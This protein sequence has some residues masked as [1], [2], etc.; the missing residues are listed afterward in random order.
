MF[1]V[2]VV[3]VNHYLSPPVVDLDVNF[4]DF[5]NTKVTQVPV[6]RIFGS[7]PAGQKTCLHV[8]GV[9]P[10]FYVPCDEAEVSLKFLQ[11]LALS[12][13]TALQVGSGNAAKYV[14]HVF[15]IIPVS[16]RQL[17][18]YRSTERQF[19]KIYFYNPLVI[20][21][22]SELLQ[23]GA[24]LNRVFQPYECHVPFN[25]QFF[26]DYN[27]Y[28]MNLVNLAAVKFR[29]SKNDDS[30][31][32]QSNFTESQLG[33]TSMFNSVSTQHW[34][35]SNIPG[36]Q[37]LP[38]DVNRQSTC[39]LE[40]DGVATD[41]LNRLDLK[42]H[43]DTN[44][45]LVAIWED[46][47]QR[48]EQLDQLSQLMPPASPERGE[49]MLQEAES[50]WLE[51]LTEVVDE[52]LKELE[53]H[54]PTSEDDASRMENKEEQTAEK[55]TDSLPTS[56]SM[57]NQ[58]VDH[59]SQDEASP[60]QEDNVEAVV[61]EELALSL[62]QVPVTGLSQ[63]ADKD[64]ANLLMELGGGDD[65]DSDSILSTQTPAASQE[66]EDGRTDDAAEE[67]EA[68]EKQESLEMSQ[69]WIGDD[70]DHD[71]EDED[72]ET[73]EDG[74]EPRE[75]Q[76]LNSSLEEYLIPDVEEMSALSQPELRSSQ[77]PQLDG[78]NDPIPEK[79]R[80]KSKLE[81]VQEMRAIRA[82]HQLTR[83]LTPI[84]PNFSPN[85][86]SVKSPSFLHSLT[87]GGTNM[88]L[89]M[90]RKNVGPQDGRPPTTYS[91]E[92]VELYSQGY[93]Q[94]MDPPSLQNRTQSFV[95]STVFAECVGSL[96]GGQKKLAPKRGRPPGAFK[97]K[98]GGF[99]TTSNQQLKHQSHSVT[100]SLPKLS[101]DE[102]HIRNGSPFSES[103][104]K[105]VEKK[106]GR[107]PLSSKQR[108]VGLLSKESKKS[109]KGRN[110][111]GSSKSKSKGSNWHTATTDEK[112]VST[113][114]ERPPS[115]SKHREDAASDKVSK[116]KDISSDGAV[117]IVHD[118]SLVGTIKHF[119]NGSSKKPVIKRGR[120][121]KKKKIQFVGTL[122]ESTT[123]SKYVN[124]SSDV[125]K[126][127][128]CNKMMDETFLAKGKTTPSTKEK[129]SSLQTNLPPSKSTS[130]NTQREQ[131]SDEKLSAG[132]ISHTESNTKAFTIKKRRGRPPLSI[133]KQR[134]GTATSPESS[135][136][137]LK[138][139][140]NEVKSLAIVKEGGVT[141]LSSS[142]VKPA[143]RRGRPPSKWK[144]KKETLQS[145][146]LPVF[147]EGGIRESCISHISDAFQKETDV[148]SNSA[149]NGTLGFKG[150]NTNKSDEVLVYNSEVKSSDNLW[151]SPASVK[152]IVGGR[153][154][155]GLAQKKPRKRGR[156]PL[157]KKKGENLHDKYLTNIPKQRKD[158]DG[159]S[160]MFLEMSGG[161][162]KDSSSHL[163]STSDAESD[164][165][166]H[167]I[168]SDGSPSLRRL[169]VKL[170]KV[171]LSQE[172]KEPSSLSQGA[173]E[174]GDN[175]EKGDLENMPEENLGQS[176]TCVGEVKD[177]VRE[178]TERRKHKKNVK[179]SDKSKNT[180]PRHL[181]MRRPY[182]YSSKILG[183][184]KVSVMPTDVV[185]RD[186]FNVSGSSL[187]A[188][189]V[190]RDS[191]TVE[192]TKL[193]DSVET[194]ENGS[195]SNPLCVKDQKGKMKDSP[196]SSLGGKRLF[197]ESE[198][199]IRRQTKSQK[200][201]EQMSTNTLS[202]NL[203]KEVTKDKS[204][205][206]L[207]E[208]KEGHSINLNEFT[209]EQL[210]SMAVISP[211]IVLYRFGKGRSS[212]LPSGHDGGSHDD[213]EIQST[214]KMKNNGKEIQTK[215]A[216]ALFQD[217]SEKVSPLL[218]SIA[219]QK[220]YIPANSKAAR[221][222]KVSK[223]RGGGRVEYS[224]L[225]GV[226]RYVKRKKDS[227]HSPD[228]VPSQNGGKDGDQNEVI[229]LTSSSSSPDGADKTSPQEIEILGVHGQK[230]DAL[231]KS[232]MQLWTPNKPSGTKKK[233]RLSKGSHSKKIGK[234]KS[235]GSSP[236]LKPQLQFLLTPSKLESTK[237]PK[238]SQSS[239]SSKKSSQ[240]MPQST[241]Q[242][243]SQTPKRGRGRPRKLKLDG[244]S[245]TDDKKKQNKEI[246]D[247]FP[248]TKRGR[249]EKVG[250]NG[251]GLLG[252]KEAGKD[253][254]GDAEDDISF[255]QFLP[256]KDDDNMNL[257][258]QDTK[259][260]EIIDLLKDD[261][262]SAIL[263]VEKEVEVSST[264]CITDEETSESIHGSDPK[265]PFLRT[266]SSSPYRDVLWNMS[267]TS[268]A[269]SS[270]RESPPK[271]WSPTD[272][273]KKTETYQSEKSEQGAMVKSDS[274]SQFM[275]SLD[276]N[277]NKEGYSEQRRE[278]KEG[279]G[280]DSPSLSMSEIGEYGNS[281]MAL[282]EELQT[283]A[284]SEETFEK[285]DQLSDIVSD[286]M[287][288]AT[289]TEVPSEAPPPEESTSE[290][291]KGVTIPK[292]MS[293]LPEAL[294]GKER[295]EGSEV[296]KVAESAASAKNTDKKSDVCEPGEK[297]QYDGEAG[298]S[299]GDDEEPLIPYPTIPDSI[300]EASE[301]D[302]DSS[303]LELMDSVS[304]I[305]LLQSQLDSVTTHDPGHEIFKK[306]GEMP[307]SNL[308]LACVKDTLGSNEKEPMQKESMNEAD[309][310][311][312]GGKKPDGEGSPVIDFQGTASQAKLLSSLDTSSTSCGNE[313]SHEESASGLKSTDKAKESIGLKET[314]VLDE[315]DDGLHPHESSKEQNA[316][317]NGK[318]ELDKS[319]R[320][321]INIFEMIG[322]LYKMP[323]QKF[324]SDDKS[325]T[326][327]RTAS[328]IDQRQ[329]DEED[330]SSSPVL[331]YQQSTIL[332]GMSHSTVAAG[333]E[334]KVAASEESRDEDDHTSK[335]K[336]AINDKEVNLL[337]TGSSSPVLEFQGSSSQM[338]SLQK[339]EHL[340]E[341]RE[342]Q[343]MEDLSQKEGG[344]EI[345]NLSETEKEQ[346]SED[347]LKDGESQKTENLLETGKDQKVG[348]LSK[349]EEGQN[350]EDL[351]EMEGPKIEDL[352]EAGEWQNIEDV[353][354]PEGQKNQDLSEKGKEQKTEDLLETGEEQKSIH[355]LEQG[356]GIGEKH[357]QKDDQTNISGM[358]MG[359]ASIQSLG[360]VEKEE[361]EVT[362]KQALEDEMGT[363]EDV[364]D[365]SKEDKSEVDDLVERV[366]NTHPLNEN[367]VSA[368]QI[369]VGEDGEVVS[370]QEK[371]I[372]STEVN[373]SIKETDVF[374]TE[375]GNC[376]DSAIS[377]NDDLSPVSST[378]VKSGGTL[379]VLLK[380][381]DLQK[382]PVK[383]S[384]S[385]SI[386]C[387]EVEESKKKHLDVEVLVEGKEENKVKSYEE[388][389]EKYDP[390]E[391]MEGMVKN[392]G[393]LSEIHSHNER[394]ILTDSKISEMKTVNKSNTSSSEQRI[395]S[396]S[397][398]D[399]SVFL[400]FVRKRKEPSDLSNEQIKH[401]ENNQHPAKRSRRGSSNDGSKPSDLSQYGI[402]KELNIPLRRLSLDDLPHSNQWGT[403]RYD[404][405]DGSTCQRRP[406]LD[407]ESMYMIEHSQFQLSDSSEHDKA[408]PCDFHDLE[409]SLN[410]QDSGMSDF[411]ESSDDFEKGK[412]KSK[413]RKGRKESTSKK[414]KK[415]DK[416]KKKKHRKS[417]DDGLDRKKRNTDLVG[418]SELFS[419]E[420]EENPPI[421][422]VFRK[423]RHNKQTS[424]RAC[425][426]KK[427]TTQSIDWKLSEK[428]S[429]AKEISQAL[430]DRNPDLGVES[431]SNA[432]QCRELKT[433]ILRKVNANFPGQNSPLEKSAGL[434][435]KK[436][437]HDRCER[438]LTD[439]VGSKCLTPPTHKQIKGLELEQA[440]GTD[441]VGVGP[442]AIR[443]WNAYAEK[444]G[445][446]VQKENVLLSKEEEF[447]WNGRAE[448]R[449]TGT[450]V[451]SQ[452]QSKLN[453]QGFQTVKDSTQTVC[454]SHVNQG[455]KSSEARLEYSEMMTSKLSGVEDISPSIAGLT[456]V[457]DGKSGGLQ[458]ESK[459][460]NKLTEESNDLDI[461]SD[462]N[463]QRGDI[464]LDSSGEQ[465]FSVKEDH[466]PVP[467]E[468]AVV[469][470]EFPNN[471]QSHTRKMHK[472]DM[473]MRSRLNTDETEVIE[474]LM[475]LSSDGSS[476][477]TRRG[478]EKDGGEPPDQ[479]P[480]LV[481]FTEEE[482]HETEYATSF[483][484]ESTNEMLAVPTGEGKSCQ[485]VEP[486]PS[487]AQSAQGAAQA[488]ES[489]V[490]V[491]QVV[492]HEIEG[493][494]DIPCM[495]EGSNSAIVGGVFIP[496]KPPP[497]RTDISST[498]SEYGLPDVVH[499]V[500]YWEK[501]A[502]IPS[503]V[504][505]TANMQVHLN[506]N[507]PGGLKEALP[508]S[509]SLGLDHWRTE[510]FV[511]NQSQVVD[512]QEASFYSEEGKAVMKGMLESATCKMEVV[513]TP[514]KLP[515][516]VCDVTRWLK[517]QRTNKIKFPAVPKSTAITSRTL[518]KPK[519]KELKEKQNRIDDIVK[520]LSGDRL[521][522]A[523]ITHSSL[524]EA[525]PSP[526]LQELIDQV[527]PST[528]PMIDTP[529]SPPSRSV[530]ETPPCHSTPLATGTKERPTQPTLTPILIT[531]TKK[532]EPRLKKRVSLV[533]VPKM[534]QPKVVT[535]GQASMV[536]PLAKKGS[537]TSQLEGPTPKNTG[538]FKFSQF[539]LQDAKA[540]HENQHLTLMSLELHV[541]TRGKL[542][543]DP[544]FDPVRAIFFCIASENYGEGVGDGAQSEYTGVITVDNPNKNQLQTPT[545]NRPLLSTYGLPDV[546]VI[547]ASDEMEMFEK[548]IELIQSHDPDFLI[549]YEIQ[550]LSWGYLL[551]RAAALD[552]KLC[553]RISRLPDNEKE[554]HFSSE[555]DA[556]GS[557]HTSEIHIGGRIVLNVW[558]LLRHEIALNIYTFEN[559]A[560]HVLHQRVPLYSF[561]DLSAWYDHQ[562]HLLRWRVVEHYTYRVIGNL[563]I[564]KQM[565][566]I[567]RTSEL[568]RLFGIEFFSV[569]SRGSQYRVESMMLRQA[570]SQNYVA[571]SPSV[572][573][574]AVM[575]APECLP[576]ILE[577]ESKLYEDPVIVL[578][579]QSLYPSMMIGY[580]YCF[581]TCIGR[582]EHIAKGGHF[583]LGCTTHYLSPKQIKQLL[584]S[585]GLHISPNGVV[586]VK[587][588][589]RH[590]ILPRMLEQI[591]QTRV[592]VKKG[593]KDHKQDKVL[594][595]MLDNRQLGLKLIANVTYGYTSASF[596]G[597]M[598]CI[599]VGDS[600]VMKARETLERSIH[601]IENTPKWGARVVYGDTDSMFVMVKGATKE[602][603]FEVGNEIVAA[604]SKVNPKPVKLK[605]EKVYKPCVLQAK[606]R[607]VGFKY[608]SPD[609]KEPELEAKGIETIRRDTC[610]AVAKILEKS[611][612][613][614]FTTQNVSQV[615]QYVQ[616]QFQ[617]IIDGRINQQ[618]LV[619]AKEYRGRQY[620]KP[621]ACI[622]ALE[623]TKRS[624][625]VD[626]RSEPRVG[627]RV[628]YVIVNGIPGL[629]LI[630]LVRR[631][632]ELA[633]DPTLIINSAYYITRQLVPSL[634]R[635]FGIMG[636]ETL[637][638]YQELPRNLR[639][640]TAPTTAQS[641][642]S[643]KG[644]ISQYFCSLNCIICDQLTKTGLCEDCRKQP[645]LAAA[646]L[647]RKIQEYQRSWIHLTKI[648]RNCTGCPEHRP[649]CI[650]IDCPNRFRIIR[651]SQKM[652]SIPHL[653]QLLSELPVS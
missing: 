552:V 342:E 155:L 246:S 221:Q 171:Q 203:P 274:E 508:P 514:C 619:F 459:E 304:Q 440:L 585:G 298:D 123:E 162:L 348:Y 367:E 482:A 426:S 443:E 530:S 73:D 406:A 71:D 164:D 365:G 559:V 223:K 617:K 553:S 631:P 12:I 42:D 454:D 146:K 471:G 473:S 78:P 277:S 491:D 243:A 126:V 237:S 51:R 368:N 461:I 11:Q 112:T 432:E 509:S 210:S 186:S 504:R 377:W 96:E 296:E 250:N 584:D 8:H 597:R 2:R 436:V 562:T 201:D 211:K 524:E 271:Y 31:Q 285:K 83:S 425:P 25:L 137:S 69:V 231:K 548:F 614:I 178:S 87:F 334:D 79:R 77:L 239:R 66:A 311:P 241:Q 339:F 266:P 613:I 318:L 493:S 551:D 328:A 205:L 479:G 273:A 297:A 240:K 200:V 457:T 572:Q 109:V 305:E 445:G 23:N 633:S 70:E 267:F 150:Q 275:D 293:C 501:N 558:R 268:P 196:V 497:T 6:I 381:Q 346:K 242:N 290:E 355:L 158:Q 62:S 588:N 103:V 230:K 207:S 122:S 474:A 129:K 437:P 387:S 46:E 22:A 308:D 251:R 358:E 287:K 385:D 596:S 410:L 418:G 467:D 555:K 28:G 469:Q 372:K 39:E 532:T 356:Q 601:L 279:D 264:P 325:N 341:K 204:N 344:Q 57:S 370:V 182:S 405:D 191:V 108:K 623:L 350:I 374:L 637:Q 554:S 535:P 606:K 289:S 163:T 86:G 389:A 505:E 634:N 322:S 545:S 513:L 151:I 653:V 115:G 283:S 95:D 173:C 401:S 386:S 380:E 199:D 521:R 340:S 349:T 362:E 319:P 641:N 301:S 84:T 238:S 622:P 570:K 202:D 336:E 442:D 407:F 89:S 216:S 520:R 13:D 352:I 102:F 72:E 190:E 37:W 612:K 272:H 309:Q 566:L 494:Q 20:R 312:E 254:P 82:S 244:V 179:K 68:A 50:D 218:Q 525:P 174:T 448:I 586:F 360:V 465:V 632:E 98:A 571:L 141:S 423:V 168:H 220:K 394:S 88:N 587:K 45:G 118:D 330:G 635:V 265:Y 63:A 484:E 258:S 101:Q 7:T 422:M 569:L 4:S 47:R 170:T 60:P 549:G 85:S 176:V 74:E 359:S 412:V 299:N 582:V 172:G 450:D 262:A 528:P 195:V 544:D 472:L 417:E 353:L 592:M 384:V 183:S 420:S 438:P 281:Q 10:Y 583:V 404:D 499:Q 580:N 91:Q 145:Q 236:A 5:R 396:T 33:E 573:Q 640:T 475:G 400:K 590:G 361:S 193:A 446:S 134:E 217:N 517:N 441:A 105:K 413:N 458:R 92:G 100:S 379:H 605:L 120:P 455:S 651:S 233:S 398:E 59:F 419:Q 470:T 177:L 542:R 153:K 53:E 192:E 135:P 593:L 291:S 615:K 16:G 488:T 81:M 478:Q 599:E 61:N 351:F 213:R 642:Q 460:G 326:E 315:H 160:E 602:R 104:E 181:G 314:Y 519:S 75:K 263:N 371:E 620:Y 35:P 630:Q 260:D 310:L 270:P 565:D 424:P 38:E 224:L 564:L 498:L 453:Q 518:L 444:S 485:Q 327:E 603:A 288:K 409:T 29:R 306:G 197:E 608:E 147:M 534:E 99:E 435:N 343:T 610:P 589:V 639:V 24:I 54:L 222:R 547:N 329:E 399:T 19:L 232:D 157:K 537:F 256:G 206:F 629:P 136:P 67:E 302:E 415:K 167:G 480:S 40:V 507:L 402:E 257:S 332:A 591:L 466:V 500:P 439:S 142:D 609:Q 414:K 113:K 3:T 52:Q 295:S 26:I 581:S 111:L 366:P 576:L 512:S 58:L 510:V 212:P 49:M 116:H 476:V 382:V 303:P 357:S 249:G 255:I 21:R 539:N 643:K 9:F 286:G 527:E 114:R 647:S 110:D 560:Y 284:A 124:K 188:D 621:G 463:M 128:S 161:D 395:E 320:D 175:S 428:P 323:S 125:G 27:L 650:S 393:N 541:H 154:T 468:K 215:I 248:V 300:S 235:P 568:A 187:P 556:Y 391:V 139:P 44:P 574:R 245:Q 165:T 618:D 347:V 15:K 184:D 144:Q 563:K 17:Y 523:V 375:K 600:I 32:N 316:Q 567:G 373:S 511:R 140:D 276:Q 421:K 1:S 152:G 227:S 495:E 434:Y 229:D 616:K 604:V 198:M 628:P 228:E 550:Q 354:E 234:E 280:R 93:H 337:T 579:F 397:S 338:N 449:S 427:K 411:E 607:Y 97:Q 131:T 247:Y 253:S 636:V 648:C 529:E 496:V 503:F 43:V 90:S 490:V 219:Q 392:G 487:A 18:G 364:K 646:A 408:N 159:P 431:S 538:A 55:E 278:S 531:A 533:D 416:E 486:M 483:L 516:K 626:K 143:K 156:P 433:L 447:A 127:S 403:S 269:V 388:Q 261:D 540:L 189:V 543:P 307:K 133:T 451:G 48:R 65:I 321:D 577:P 331:E 335:S 64:L 369:E 489:E 481:G 652:E 378:K 522:D 546:K 526:F 34:S 80:K 462:K 208:L 624:L 180:K 625:A 94:R 429:S 430:Q 390:K 644:T 333:K 611:L 185:G 119:D 594:Q 149:P 292:S 194:A 376:T 294:N 598:P 578:D 14:Q 41:I 345:E 464:P 649:S 138:V 452:D 561:Q 259:L 456:S 148:A 575:K 645:Q 225:A 317:V 76:E 536:T 166:F 557:D 595:R 324:C 282:F 132:E 117:N 214:P 106:K 477:S 515:P 56:Q 226:K 638:W 313:M 506:Q 209:S 107:P 502:D 30:T 492:T 130:P 36:S 363:R 169:K 383:M 627:E 252:D 121:P